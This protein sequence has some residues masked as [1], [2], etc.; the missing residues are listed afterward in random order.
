MEREIRGGRDK[1]RERKKNRE[2]ERQRDRETE[3]ERERQR[4][5]QRERER[6]RER[7]TDRERERER[8]RA[9]YRF[10][11]CKFLFQSKIKQYKTIHRPYLR[12]IIYKCNIYPSIRER[13]GAFVVER[14]RGEKESDHSGDRLDNNILEGTNFTL[15]EEVR[16]H[17]LV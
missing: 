1:E 17:S 10:E 9:T 7:Q 2:T 4:E 16:T 12:D 6:E 8:E 13:E 3:G 11:W 14:E 5:G 15:I